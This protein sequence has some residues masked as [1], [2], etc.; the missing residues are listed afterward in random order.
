M[1]NKDQLYIGKLCDS[2][3]GTGVICWV[4]DNARYIYMSDM[5]GQQHH[6]VNFDELTDYEVD[7]SK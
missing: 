3:L 2:P 4:D 1:I 6:K 7:E 5:Q